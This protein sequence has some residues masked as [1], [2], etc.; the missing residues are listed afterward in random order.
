MALVIGN[1]ACLPHHPSGDKGLYWKPF[2]RETLCVSTRIKTPPTWHGLG[3]G[4]TP[5]WSLS[6]TVSKAI[7]LIRL[8]IE[9]V[10]IE[11]EQ[12]SM[13]TAMV[14]MCKLKILL[15]VYR[16]LKWSKVVILMLIQIRYIYS[17]ISWKKNLSLKWIYFCQ[18]LL[19]YLL[20]IYENILAKHFKEF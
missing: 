14:F 13:Y 10:C 12:K 4:P 5:S 3:F 18:Y 17:Q 1:F 19:V 20:C 16:T 7:T 11:M 9:S 6:F 8:A 15:N 2:S